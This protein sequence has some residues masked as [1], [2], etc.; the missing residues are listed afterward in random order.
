MQFWP[1]KKTREKLV[2]PV[3]RGSTAEGG[4]GQ[5][6]VSW[7]SWRAE[8]TQ[9]NVPSPPPI[10]IRNVD[11]FRKAYNLEWNG[12]IGNKRAPQTNIEM[13]LWKYLPRQRTT[14]HEIVDLMRIEMTTK[15]RQKFNP[16][17]TTTLAIDKDEKR[18]L[19]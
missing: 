17:I 2:L 19:V 15:T 14:V 9:P 16:L 3:P 7:I 6:R 1:I 10:K 12:D 4:E 5:S 13:L 18:L 11:I 8:R